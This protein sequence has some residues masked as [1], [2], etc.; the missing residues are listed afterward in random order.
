MS[1][2]PH[3]P[4][5]GTCEIRKNLHYIPDTH[6]TRGRTSRC[7]Q[8][9]STNQTPHPTTKAGR[10]PKPHPIPHTLQGNPQEPAPASNETSPRACCLKA[11]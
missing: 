7:S 3:T 8:P 5:K 11:Q 6:P 2:H 10:Q 9:L 1:H 4:H